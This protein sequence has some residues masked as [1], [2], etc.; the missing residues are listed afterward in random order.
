MLSSGMILTALD[1]VGDKGYKS[2]YVKMVGPG[3]VFIGLG[4]VIIR[5]V[6]LFVQSCKI[7][8]KQ[9]KCMRDKEKRNSRIKERQNQIEITLSEPNPMCA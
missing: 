3:L 9:S 7:R 4:L 6:C 8:K 5:I 2:G 1:G